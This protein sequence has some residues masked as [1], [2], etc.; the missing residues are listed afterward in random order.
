MDAGCSAPIPCDD[1][2]QFTKLL[3]ARRKADDRIR[4]QL[5][6]LLPTASFVDKVDCRSKCEGFLKEM[7]LDHEK[8]NDAIKH[9]VNNTASRL[10]ELKE[11]RAKAS[12]DEKHSVSRSF[13]RQQL[14]VTAIS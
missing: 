3:S 2:L 7:L 11:L 12:P 13:R 1:F 5:N 4:N 8:R 10:E 9:C 14:L 6:A